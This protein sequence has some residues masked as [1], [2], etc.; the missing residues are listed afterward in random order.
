MGRLEA[1]FRTVVAYEDSSESRQTIGIG[2]PGFCEMLT[3][4]LARILKMVSKVVICLGSTNCSQIGA[5]VSRRL[6]TGQG[7]DCF[8][9]GYRWGGYPK[10]VSAHVRM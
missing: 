4:M 6:V 7:E 3:A 5:V 8:V 2:L 9:Q 1:K 10:T